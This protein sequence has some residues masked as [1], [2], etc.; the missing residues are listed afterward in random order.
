MDGK[1]ALVLVALYAVTRAGR[2]Q[3]ELGPSYHAAG[4]VLR[5]LPAQIAFYNSVPCKAAA[6]TIQRWPRNHSHL[7]VRA[8]GPLGRYPGQR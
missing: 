7:V 4:R 6:V 1:R 2:Y 8:A 3:T 5:P